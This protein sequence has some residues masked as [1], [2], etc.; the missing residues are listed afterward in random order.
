MSSSLTPLRG[1]TAFGRVGGVRK[2]RLRKI[3]V[4]FPI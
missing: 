3:T 1:L 4:S 2:K